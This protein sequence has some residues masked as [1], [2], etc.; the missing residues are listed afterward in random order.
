MEE[1]LRLANQ[2]QDGK[3]SSKINSGQERRG[4]GE[5]GGGGGGGSGGRQP[6][7]GWKIAKNMM[8]RR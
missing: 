1:K 2:I 7:S 6:I 3:V 5:G 4:V 8:N